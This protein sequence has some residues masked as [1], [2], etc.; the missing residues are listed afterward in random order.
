MSVWTIVVAAGSGARFGGPKQLA[1]LVGRPVLHWA[2]STAV[3]ASDGVVVVVPG[4]RIDE[5]G[6]LLADLVS[7]GGLH[8]VAGGA[9]RSGSVRNGL[10]VVPDHVEIVLVHDGARPLADAALF[11]AIADAVRHGADCAIPV[12][13]VTDTIRNTD[14][15][16]VDRDRLVAVQTPQ[17]FT[18]SAL[19]SAHVTSADATDD[20][21]LV[22]ANGGKVVHVAS[23]SENLKITTPIDLVVA[24]AILEARP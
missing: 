5:V 9:T 6:T 19:R 15:G 14:G 11:D 1:T 21:G 23:T 12:V 8:V 24:E 17:G 3:T 18:S 13:P 16:V 10:A 4:E 22:E 7:N 2:V 20:A